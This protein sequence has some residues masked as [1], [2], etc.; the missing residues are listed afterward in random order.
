MNNSAVPCPAWCSFSLNNC[1][2]FL[3]FKLLLPPKQLLRFFCRSE[4]FSAKRSPPCFRAFLQFFHN[5]LPVFSQ[6]RS[7]IPINNCAHFLTDHESLAFKKDCLIFFMLCAVYQKLIPPILSCHVQF[8]TQQLR[9]FLSGPLLISTIAPFSS[10]FTPCRFIPKIF[11]SCSS[12][13]F[14]FGGGKAAAAETKFW[15]WGFCGEEAA[16][17]RKMIGKLFGLLVKK[18]LRPAQNSAGLD[19]GERK[20][21]GVEKQSPRLLG[22]NVGD[23][24]DWNRYGA[25]KKGAKLFG[26]KPPLAGQ[27]S[28]GLDFVERKRHAAENSLHDKMYGSFSGKNGT[29]R[30]KSVESC[31][32]ESGTGTDKILMVGISWEGFGGEETARGRKKASNI[33]KVKSALCPKNGRGVGGEKT[34]LEQA[35][36]KGVF[37]KKTARGGKMGSKLFVGKP[38][39]DG[40]NSGSVK[41]ALGRKNE[42]RAGVQKT[43]MG[44]AKCRRVFVGKTAHFVQRKR[45]GEEKMPLWL[46]GCKPP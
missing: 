12:S 37:G 22:Q 9:F 43:A 44:Q 42:S 36:C 41:A 45:H 35:N 34:A 38:P 2:R 29:W 26:G 5:N 21:Q 8:P 17:G 15:R 46:I 6:A 32:D 27:N 25:E 28:A 16:R 31:L 7:G 18:P 1:A 19:F 4:T 3:S 23:F 30:K 14:P 39:R 24:V 11:P 10:C 40:Q 13:P 20:R 33:D